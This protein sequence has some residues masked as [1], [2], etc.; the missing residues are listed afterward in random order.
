MRAATAATVAAAASDASPI[1]VFTTAAS[2]LSVEQ[3]QER[4][5]EVVAQGNCY[6]LKLDANEA[7]DG[8]ML[9]IIEPYRR[10]STS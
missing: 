5:N 9:Y 2:L 6:I 10:R 7:K 8:L 1:T 4:F 3:A